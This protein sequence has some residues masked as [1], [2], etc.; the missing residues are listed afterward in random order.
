MGEKTSS[1]EKCGM[2]GKKKTEDDG[3][4]SGTE[5]RQRKGPDLA[6]LV[7]HRCAGDPKASIYTKNYWK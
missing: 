5:K 3:K 2:Q 7:G 4:N 1:G 6:D